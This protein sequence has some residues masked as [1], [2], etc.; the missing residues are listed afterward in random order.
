MAHASQNPGGPSGFYDK[1]HV[2]MLRFRGMES[3]FKSAE[4]FIRHDQSPQHLLP[5]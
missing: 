4:A 2:P 1:D 5:E 3:G